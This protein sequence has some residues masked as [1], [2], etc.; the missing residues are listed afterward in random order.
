MSAGS[1]V[2]VPV[3][4]AQ[5]AYCGGD[6]FRGWRGR[7]TRPS[8]PRRSRPTG[9]CTQACSTRSTLR[10]PSTVRSEAWAFAAPVLAHDALIHATGLWYI[11][12]APTD[13]SSRFLDEPG[14]APAYS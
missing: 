5:C 7:V 8:T 11:V 6:G 4:P 12:S 13:Q 3:G 1:V 14:S 2:L 10:Y 9:M